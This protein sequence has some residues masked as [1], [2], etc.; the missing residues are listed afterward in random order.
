VGTAALT[1]TPDQPALRRSHRDPVP[2]PD[3]VTRVPAPGTADGQRHGHRL[4]W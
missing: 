1:R 2:R 4:G 3:H